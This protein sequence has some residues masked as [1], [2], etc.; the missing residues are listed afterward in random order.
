MSERVT[1]AQAIQNLVRDFALA[2]PRRTAGFVVALV[3]AGLLEGLS[4]I[5]LLP[6]FV[7]G[8]TASSGVLAV[9]GIEP[10]LAT[11]LALAVVLISLKGAVSWWA[12]LQVADAVTD[13]TAKLRSQLISSVL[14]A[15][16]SYFTSRPLGAFT[17]AL[18]GE[19]DRT[20]KAYEALC[21]VAA[22][23]VQVLVYLALALLLSWKMAILAIVLGA[24]LTFV[25]RR[26]ARLDR[27]VGRE[28][29]RLFKLLSIRI[30]DGLRGIKPLKAMARETALA[31]FLEDNVLRLNTALK[32]SIVYRRAVGNFGEPVIAV[33]LA[34]VIYVGSTVFELSLAALLV[35]AALFFRLLTRL[36]HIQQAWFTALHEESAYRSLKQMLQDADKAREIRHGGA[37]PP[38]PAVIEL[39][40]V[41]F[42]YGA[43]RVLEAVN[44][45]LAPGT[46]TTVTGLSGSGK[47]TLT[48]LIVG[49]RQPSS[50]RITVGGLPLNEIDTQTWR[51]S[52]GYVPQEF[53][54]FNDSILANLTLGDAG[55]TQDRAIDALRQADAWSF[56]QRLPQGLATSVGEA[57]LELSGGQRQ[58]IALARALLR[59]PALLILDEATSSLDPETEAGI[60]R[61]IQTLKH[62]LVVLVVTHQPGWLDVSDSVYRLPDNHSA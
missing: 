15:Q 54:L 11:A 39:A 17:N 4:I 58:R 22:Y 45:R 31:Q 1:S 14:R 52:I 34:V 7:G 27:N 28:Q 37:L 23:A 19:A 9:L 48:E 56:V 61:T 41:G 10:D 21:Q 49:L 5:A 55:I 25:L 36:G 29:T 60:C 57:G 26:L 13:V 47:T 12:T 38:L 62:S 18:S 6:F 59:R 2:A 16:W 40:D 53:S 32:R 44:L 33:A 8:E 46:I 50:G 35:M 30:A 20:G 24:A 3:A 42:S 51:E 43:K